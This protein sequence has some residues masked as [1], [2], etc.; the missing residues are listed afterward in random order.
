[1]EF[2]QK[3]IAFSNTHFGG[4]LI[5]LLGVPIIMAP[6]YLNDRKTGKLISG[7]ILGL[8]AGAYINNSLA[9]YEMPL[10]MLMLFWAYKATSSWTFVGIG[11]ITHAV[12][13]IIHHSLGTPM[14][15][16]YDM[17]SLGCAVLDIILGIWFLMG[18]KY[19]PQ[20]KGASIY[21]TI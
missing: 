21:T 19:L 16:Y 6:V 3:L 10:A 1:M 7:V 2:L 4:A 9:V 15:S 17:S 12:V 8:A 5:G 20:K 11:W 18:E 13:D 14:F